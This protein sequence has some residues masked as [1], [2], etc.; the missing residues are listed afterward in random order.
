MEEHLIF[1]KGLWG[2]YN[3][4]DYASPKNLPLGIAAAIATGCG[5]MGAVLGMAAE[6]YVGVIGSKSE[7]HENSYFLLTF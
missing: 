3:P 1:R 4:E 2:N 7:F 5:V 6:W